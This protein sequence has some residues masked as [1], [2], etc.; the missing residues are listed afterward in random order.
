MD[1]CVKYQEDCEACQRFRNIQLAPAGVMN[2]IVK[3]WPFRGW[4]LYFI[5]EIQPRS[6]KGHRFILVAT[7]YSTKWTE[8]VSLRNMTHQ[9]VINF[10][11]EHIIY[12]FWVPQSLTTD[13]GPSCRSHQFREIAESMKIK[14]LNSSPYYAKANGQVE[15]SNKVLIK[16]IKKRIKDNPGRWHEKLLEALWAHRTSRI[17]AMKVTPFELVYGQEA[18]LSVE[19]GLQSLRV[20]EQGSLSAKEYHELMMDKIDDAQKAD[21]KRWKR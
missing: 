8:A 6:S 16:I 3:P 20:T 21:L 13:Q 4:G 5:S 17:G 10:V 1:D 9:E 19:I 12:Q 18:V 15:A 14:L 11:H 2:S 7:D